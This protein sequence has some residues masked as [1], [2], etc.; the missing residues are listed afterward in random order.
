MVRQ[1]VKDLLCVQ[2][3]ENKCL[4]QWLCFQLILTQMLVYLYVIFE[5]LILPL[6]WPLLITQHLVMYVRSN[7]TEVLMDFVYYT[8]EILLLFCY[9]PCISYL[10]CYSLVWSFNHGTLS[11]YN[12]RLTKESI[13]QCSVLEKHQPI[14]MQQLVG[15]KKKKKK[16]SSYL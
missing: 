15:Y 16:L 12:N 10:H 14:G 6:I 9:T 13:K 7:E 2:R 8:P 3:E 5:L 4:R 1:A 11:M